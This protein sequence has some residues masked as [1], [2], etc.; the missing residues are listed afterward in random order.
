MMS[1]FNTFIITLIGLIPRRLVKFI[2]YKYVAGI[3]SDSAIQTVKELN[4]KNFQSP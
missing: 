2:A 3:S 1:Y 4:K